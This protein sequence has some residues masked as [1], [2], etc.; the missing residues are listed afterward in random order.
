MR[1][2]GTL[3][4]CLDH[5]AGRGAPP[6]WSASMERLAAEH[7][8]LQA[9]VRDPA[10]QVYGANTL[11]GHR[12]D[13][14]VAE[15]A[16]MAAEILR[17]HAIAAPPWLDDHAVRCIGYAK[18]YSWAAGLSGASPGLFDGV[19]ELVRSEDFR[20][21]VPRGASYSC[22]DVIPAAHWARAALH[23]LSASGAHAV[24]PGEIM[25]LINGNFVHVGLAVA[26]VARLER[27]SVLAVEAAALFHSI[28]GANASNLYFVSTAERAW[29]TNAVRYIA[30]RA[31]RP[32]AAADVQ[33]PVSMRAIPQVLETW[34]VAVDDFL[35]ETNHLLFKPSCNPFVDPRHAFPISQASFLAPTLS[36]KTGAL[37]E[38]ALFLMWAVLGWTRHLLSGRVPDV[39]RDGSTA[40]SPLGLIQYPKLMTA[41][42]E[43][44]RMNLGRRTFAAGSDTSYGIEDIW[45]N[46]VFTLAQLERALDDLDNLFCLGLWIVRRLVDDFGLGDRAR[47]DLLDACADCAS[48]RELDRRVSA[49]LDAGRPRPA[50]D[51][52]WRAR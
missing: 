6:V 52:F 12:D 48:A 42:C 43:Q 47:S 10:V 16:A 46:G 8:H 5:V 30:E 9:L 24:R 1:S 19:S 22:G 18:L 31:G 13:E 50:R 37:V 7:E 49:H 34:D 44:T 35:A 45:S 21:D 25:A 2:F 32:L 51:L 28:A 29:T 4:E 3:S 15:P 23:E 40:A 14:A 11:V 36:V 33:D 20:P 38:A 27:T 41:I 39:P 17:T 26:M